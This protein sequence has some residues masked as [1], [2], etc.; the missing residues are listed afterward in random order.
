MKKRVTCKRSKNKALFSRVRP[1][2]Q[3]LS[4]LSIFVQQHD[5]TWPASITR[6]LIIR[7]ILKYAG[8]VWMQSQ[9]GELTSK[10]W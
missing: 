1:V 8:E 5:F 9:G 7:L 10:K 2:Y 6:A 3:K 4:K